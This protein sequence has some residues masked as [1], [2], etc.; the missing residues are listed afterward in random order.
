MKLFHI[1]RTGNIE[2][3]VA[4]VFKWIYVAFQNII[5]GIRCL[6]TVVPEV[7]MQLYAPGFKAHLLIHI[8]GLKCL[9]ISNEF[10]TYTGIRQGAS[11]SVL[12]FILFMDDL[13]SYLKH[14]CVEEPI[15]SLMHCLLHANDTAILSTNRNLFIIRCNLMLQYFKDKSFFEFY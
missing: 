2:T 12:L 15:V 14:H 6:P 5:S 11:S 9:D 1:F 13:I 8:M 3:S 7:L 10:R 4:F